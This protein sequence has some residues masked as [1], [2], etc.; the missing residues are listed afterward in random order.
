MVAKLRQPSCDSLVRV[1]S[2]SADCRFSHHFS[3]AAETVPHIC[4]SYGR[5]LYRKDTVRVGRYVA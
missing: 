5:K 1:S 2:S 4:P 3:D